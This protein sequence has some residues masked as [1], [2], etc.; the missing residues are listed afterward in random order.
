MI[1]GF[2]KPQKQIF[3]FFLVQLLR[4][5]VDKN[6]GISLLR[7]AMARIYDK[8]SLSRLAIVDG[9]STMYNQATAIRSRYC[10]I[11]VIIHD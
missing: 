10:N 6:L 4:M 1:C 5:S 8:A 9:P 11:T 7:L 2:T 3:C